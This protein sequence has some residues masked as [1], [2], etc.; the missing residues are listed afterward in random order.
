MAHNFRSFFFLVLAAVLI[1]LNTAAAAPEPLVRVPSGTCAKIDK[2][3]EWWALPMPSIIP[4][5]Y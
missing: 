2:R 5:I 4:E 3:Q 1:I